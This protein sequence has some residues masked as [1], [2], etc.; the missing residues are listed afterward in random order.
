MVTLTEQSDV[1]SEPIKGGASENLP[2]RL[3]VLWGAAAIALVLAIAVPIAVGLFVTARLNEGRTL[4]SWRS[5]ATALYESML[6]LHLTGL[7]AGLILGIAGFALAGI[8]ARL[9]RESGRSGCAP[10]VWA[11]LALV[12]LSLAEFW[13]FFAPLVSFIP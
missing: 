5:G 1:K 2:L 4:P 3:R 8:G 13:A 6:V 7:V 12:V 10:M 9:C 11:S